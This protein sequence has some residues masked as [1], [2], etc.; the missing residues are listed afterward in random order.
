MTR[1]RRSRATAV[2]AF[3]ASAPVLA[4]CGVGFDANTLKPYA[5]TEATVTSAK[6]IHISQAFLLGPEPGSTLAAG[7]GTPLYLALTNSNE[8]ADTLTAATVE[9]ADTGQNGPALSLSLP[10]QQLV[11]TGNADVVVTLPS[12]VSGGEYVTVNL[13][14]SNAGAVPI[15]V[16]VIP[17]SR[18]F[19][20]YPP[21][22]PSQ[23]PAPT[24]TPTETPTADAEP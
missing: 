13:Q 21:A 14:F 2:A 12:A 11:R 24:P 6:G 19:A 18:E 17:R 10:P 20:T 8:T 16:P 9:G 23:S 5:P 1:T 3:L 15:S 4:G 7:S 22:P